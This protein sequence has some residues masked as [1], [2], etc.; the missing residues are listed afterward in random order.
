VKIKT[1]NHP[2]VFQ[3]VRGCVGNERNI[4]S[5]DTSGKEIMVAYS[6]FMISFL[7]LHFSPLTLT[8]QN[9][10]VTV[11]VCAASSCRA[12]LDKLAGFENA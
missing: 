12:C 6:R 5:N 3:Y 7:L 9:T 8:F 10:D 1:K 11:L 2:F 4:E